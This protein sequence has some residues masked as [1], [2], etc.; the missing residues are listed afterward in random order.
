MVIV[1][2]ERSTALLTFKIF[3]LLQ[4]ILFTDKKTFFQAM[5][6][7]NLQLIGANAFIKLEKAVVA[8]FQS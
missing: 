4:R 8:N 2:H 7:E 5:K 3:S 1:G 6:I